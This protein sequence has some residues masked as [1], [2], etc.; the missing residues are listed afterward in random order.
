MSV[1]ATCKTNRRSTNTAILANFP[2]A[3][4]S[5]LIFNL[6]TFPTKLPISY[7]ICFLYRNPNNPG[8]WIQVRTMLGKGLDGL[9]STI[10][11]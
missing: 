11:G 3:P 7:K 10:H 2:L 1:S 4:Q 9:K 5:I 8:K 6:A